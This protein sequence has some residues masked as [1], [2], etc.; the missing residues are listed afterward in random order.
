M[1]FCK[2]GCS[3][4]DYQM[5]PELLLDMALL[6]ARL[7][8]TLS[9]GIITD[10]RFYERSPIPW[11]QVLTALL[12]APVHHR[13]LLD[14]VHT[15]PPHLYNLQAFTEATLKRCRS[16]P[17]CQ[18]GDHSSD[19]LCEGGARTCIR[20]HDSNAHTSRHAATAPS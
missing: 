17:R 20:G 5:Q 10:Y 2:S 8:R 3:L 7:H 14:I 19:T 18:D 13:A 1:T 6:S 9:R 12:L 11:A 15:W 16:R 4:F